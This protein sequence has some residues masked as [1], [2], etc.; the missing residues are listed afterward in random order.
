LWVF[1][2]FPLFD[3]DLRDEAEVEIELTGSCSIEIAIA[4]HMAIVRSTK[5]EKKAA[6]ICHE[7]AKHGSQKWI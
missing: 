6:V 3:E 1:G 2:K 5:W 4:S 7:K